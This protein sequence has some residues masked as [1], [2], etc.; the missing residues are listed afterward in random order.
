MRQLPNVISMSRLL[1]AAAFVLTDGAWMRAGILGVAGATDILDGWVARKARLQSRAGALIDPIADR[2]FVL[3][4]VSTLLFTG[5]LTTTA[6]FILISRDIATAVGFLVA[7]AIPWLRGVEF[8]ARLTGKIVTTLQFI[9][10]VAALIA[11][12]AVT[13]LLVAVAAAS[14]WSIADYTLALWRQRARTSN[15]PAGS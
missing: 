15:Q 9:T 4:A 7:R 8:K 3:T 10:M 13:P 6:Y 14:V 2:I 1:L 11:P 12:R 5:A